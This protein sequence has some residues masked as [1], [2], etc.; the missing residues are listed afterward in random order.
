MSTINSK[1][2]ITLII[3]FLVF[4][5]VIF[6]AAGTVFWFYGWIFLILFYSFSFGFVLWLPRHDPGLIK[7]RMIGFKPDE[8]TWD[9][10]YMVLM[11]TF[12][13]IWL[14]LCRSTPFD[15]IGRRCRHGFTL[16]ERL[17]RR[18]RSTSGT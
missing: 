8:P 4:F 9:K 7:E 11:L 1:M 13:V 15:F 5:L 14:S 16:W 12:F 17:S 18:A 3:E 2:I 10:V 6:L